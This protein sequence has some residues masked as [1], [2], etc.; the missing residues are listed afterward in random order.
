M[1]GRNTIAG[2]GKVLPVGS[3]V[4]DPRKLEPGEASG[5]IPSFLITFELKRHEGQSAKTDLLACGHKA[6]VSIRVVNQRCNNVSLAID[7]FYLHS[8][9][10]CHQA[11]K[12]IFLKFWIKKPNAFAGK[13]DGLLFSTWDVSDVREAGP[14]HLS[15]SI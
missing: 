15:Y 5:I 14:V 10:E 13:E 11:S 8:N 7:S 1:Q 6:G 4:G 2:P 12:F 9:S 3:A